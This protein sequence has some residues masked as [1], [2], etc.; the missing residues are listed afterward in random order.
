MAASI[1][2]CCDEKFQGHVCLEGERGKGLPQWHGQLLWGVIWVSGMTRGLKVNLTASTLSTPQANES[3]STEDQYSIHNC[4]Q[5]HGRRW[6]LW[7]ICEQLA[8][9][10]VCWANGKAVSISS[11]TKLPIEETT[12]LDILATPKIFLDKYAE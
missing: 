1:S 2:A 3:I 4:R 5:S 12:R 10:L 7:N 9:L 8:V 11:S 6:R